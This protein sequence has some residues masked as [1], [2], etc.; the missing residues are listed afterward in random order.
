MANKRQRNDVDD[1][2]SFD[3]LQDFDNEFEFNDIEENTTIN[4]LQYR[5]RKY[6]RKLNEKRVNIAI[7]KEM[8]SKLS[9]TLA[10]YAQAIE[11]LANGT[12]NGGIII[13]D[14]KAKWPNEVLNDNERLIQDPWN[15]PNMKQR[16]FDLGSLL[17][18]HAKYFAVQWN[19]ED[20]GS[21]SSDF[22]EDFSESEGYLSADQGGPMQT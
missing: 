14:M 5:G 20:Q 10:E 16:K 9:T 11:Q 13:R 1:M 8:I 4:R 7:Y 2:T 17:Q 21:E 12:E 6:L 15:G 3:D 19:H 22:T 18:K